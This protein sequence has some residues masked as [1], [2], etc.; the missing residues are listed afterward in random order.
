MRSGS[1]T[2][3]TARQI[4]S[5]VSLCM[6]GRSWNSSPGR[7]CATSASA[8]SR[9]TSRKFATAEPWKDGSSN[10]RWRM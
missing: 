7:H 1:A 4:T 5:K 8:I 3:N 2:P 10:L 6:R 9:M